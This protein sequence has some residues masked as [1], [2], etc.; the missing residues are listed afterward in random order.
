MVLGNELPGC[1]MGREFH[2]E[3]YELT[4]TNDGALF[5]VKFGKIWKEPVVGC[6]QVL[7]HLHERLCQPNESQRL[8]GPWTDNRNVDLSNTM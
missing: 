2:E 6:F 7:F 1:V 8:A 4:G 5:N 3:A